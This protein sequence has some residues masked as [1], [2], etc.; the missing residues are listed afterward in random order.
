MKKI[1]CTKNFRILWLSTVEKK[2]NLKK[3]YIRSP[4]SLQNTHLNQRNLTL[5]VGIMIKKTKNK[6]LRENV[7]NLRRKNNNK[8]KR[9]LKIR[10]RE[11]LEMSCFKIRN[12][13]NKSKDKEIYFVKCLV[14]MWRFIED[15][16]IR[17]NYVT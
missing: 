11:Y 10:K 17:L 2:K 15:L 9:N 6:T 1:G 5:S 7:H 8:N 4:K 12:K 13:K 14:S 3:Y 16:L